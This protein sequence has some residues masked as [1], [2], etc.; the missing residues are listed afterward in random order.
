MYT[1]KSQPVINQP[2]V[3]RAVTRDESVLSGDSAARTA[4]RTPRGP[5]LLR[6]TGKSRRTAHTTHALGSRAHDN[7]TDANSKTSKAQREVTC[8]GPGSPRS[9]NLAIL[10]ATP[11]Y[12]GNASSC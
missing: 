5:I 2:N 6:Y 8:Q 1:H 9:G 11:R 10:A 3:F 7:S 4:A 12:R